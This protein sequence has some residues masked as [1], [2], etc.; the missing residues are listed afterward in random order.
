ML[1]DELD[2]HLHPRW[3]RNIIDN[4]K[5]IFPNIQFIA[6]THSPNI[7][8]NVRP[9]EIIVLEKYNNEV[10]QKELMDNEFGFKGWSVEEILTDIMGVQDTRTDIFNESIKKFERAIEQEDYKVS[11]K[12]YN[13]LN[14]L[15]HP[16]NHLRKLLK[17]D[18]ISIKDDE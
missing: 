12:T 17:F 15:L 5:S 10:K 13:E 11:K 18:L 16:N 3:Q 7:I 14:K 6:T 8:Q 4:L 1:I 2:L 9:D